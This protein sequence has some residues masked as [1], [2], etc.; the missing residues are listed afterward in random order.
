M[1][2]SRCTSLVFAYNI[3]QGALGD[4]PYNRRHMKGQFTKLRAPF[5]SLIDFE[6]V[7]AKQKEELKMGP[8]AIPCIFLG[9]HLLAGGRWH[10]DFLVA[11]LREFQ[12]LAREDWG[13]IAVQ[14]VGEV[15]QADGA[16]VFPLQSVARQALRTLVPEVTPSV[17]APAAAYAAGPFCRWI[18]GNG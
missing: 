4:S 10:G 15:F 13:N 8:T 16:A 7:P 14:R 1:V 2:A 3:D 6:S 5:G 11:D 17:A 9:W 12:S 18:G